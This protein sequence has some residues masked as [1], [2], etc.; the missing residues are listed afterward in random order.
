MI[1]VRY[2]EAF[3]FYFC[4]SIN[5]ILANICVPNVILYKDATFND[6]EHEFLRRYYHSE[7]IRNKKEELIGF[8]ESY[9]VPL[10]NL[11]IVD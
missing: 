9:K 10:P 5:E 11:A 2:F 6:S 7:E 4:K 3:Y 8:Y 1:E